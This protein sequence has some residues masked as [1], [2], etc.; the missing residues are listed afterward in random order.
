MQSIQFLKY[1]GYSKYC[2]LYNI[3]VQLRLLRII[4]SKK[5]KSLKSVYETPINKKKEH[6]Q[7]PLSVPNTAAVQETCL[8]IFVKGG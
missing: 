8:F 4:Y 5:Y 1:G 2:S 7:P 3:K 6:R